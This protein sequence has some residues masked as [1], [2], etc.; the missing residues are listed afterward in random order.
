M[1]P[2]FRRILVA[3]RGEIAIRVIRACREMGI[4]SVAVHSDV[5]ATALHTEL[6]D[7]AVEI[8]PR[9][10]ADSYLNVSAVVAAAVSS[11]AEAVHPGYGFLSENA[12][13]ARAVIDAGLVWIGPP[14]ATQEA[15]GNKLAARRAVAAA[16]VPVVPG[17]TVALSDGE[18]P[19]VA[20]I[21][22]PAM[23]K[24]AA[25]GGGRGMRR[26]SSPLPRAPHR[27]GSAAADRARPARGD[28]TARDRRR[29]SS[30]RCWRSRARPARSR[31]TASRP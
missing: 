20:A 19:D 31:S 16:G 17:Q 12:A 25:G 18:L 24:A 6:A 8:G 14:P 22:L 7:L 29:G 3:N 11:G 4:E 28:G 23:L 5:D 15:L 30:A 10:P 26:C 13:F 1:A 2:P 9:R 21:G 27:D